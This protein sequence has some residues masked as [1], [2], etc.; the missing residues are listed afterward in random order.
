ML[1]LHKKFFEH[2]CSCWGVGK[3]EGRG[4]VLFFGTNI[5]ASGKLLRV[6]SSMNKLT[7][8]ALPDREIYTYIHVHTHTHKIMYIYGQR[9]MYVTKICAE[10]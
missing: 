4:G 6:H 1:K 5:P 2:I 9:T 8:I 7:H 10:K 3:G